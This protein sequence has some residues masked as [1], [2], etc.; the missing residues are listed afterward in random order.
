MNAIDELRKTKFTEKLEQFILKKRR[1]Q[2]NLDEYQTRKQKQ[3]PYVPEDNTD[4]I[5]SLCKC[6][7]VNYVTTTCQH[8]CCQKCLFD[9]LLKCRKKCPVCS[10]E[11]KGDFAFPCL[12]IDYWIGIAQKNN[13]DYEVKLQE[14]EL[15]KERGR[16]K[17]F[18]VGMRLDILDT[19]FVWCQ[20]EVKDIRYGKNDQPKQ[21]FIHYLGWD[22]V[23]DEII[24]VDSFRL[25]PLGTNTQQKNVIQYKQSNVE[26]IQRSLNINQN[27]NS[28]AR[29]TNHRSLIMALAS[30]FLSLRNDLFN[31][32]N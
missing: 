9:H 3:Q 6:F 20:G 22:K 16:V 25:A 15:W 11:L 7:Y 12:S 28:N 5:C 27:A 26:T 1:A 32:Q 8:N 23:Y 21:V 13:K 18:T 4:Q 10:R 2:T 30:Q 14:I 17:E 19:V 31:N 29:E 24:D